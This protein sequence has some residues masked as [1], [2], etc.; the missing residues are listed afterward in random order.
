MLAPRNR[1]HPVRPHHLLDVR[2]RM[3]GGEKV[4]FQAR[5]S[6]VCAVCDE[7]WQPGDLIR[8]AD[9]DGK[10]RGRGVSAPTWVH[11]HCP[12]LPD[13]GALRPGETACPTCWLV[14]P[15]G[16]CDR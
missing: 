16:E 8:S 11:A 4:T 7:R 10:P 6:G 14:H 13:A 12:N 2:H 3:D 15:E 1:N 9:P 5:Y